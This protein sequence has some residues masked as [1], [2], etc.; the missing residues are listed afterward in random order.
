MPFESFLHVSLA[1]IGCELD[2]DHSQQEDETRDSPDHSVVAVKDSKE[3]SGAKQGDGGQDAAEV[4]A[5]PGSGGADPGGEELGQEER[6]PAEKYPVEE[7]QH[8]D[9]DEEHV[10]AGDGKPEGALRGDEG[11]KAGDQV[12]ASATHRDRNHPGEDTSHDARQ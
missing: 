12:G 10:V 1:G 4:E 9:P 7:S 8:H 6:K 11:A 2:G 5:H 3:V